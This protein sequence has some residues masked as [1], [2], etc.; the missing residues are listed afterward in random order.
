M[1]A[2]SILKCLVQPNRIPAVPVRNKGQHTVLI[3]KRICK[4]TRDLSPQKA[5]L[6]FPWTP[7]EPSL[8]ETLAPT[9]WTECSRWPPKVWHEMTTCDASQG[10]PRCQGSVQTPKHKPDICTATIGFL[11]E[12]FSHTVAALSNSSQQ[13]V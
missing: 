4:A 13:Q 11:P 8:P 5:A 9:S 7:T 10:S 1:L 12:R 2:I 6:V 3:G